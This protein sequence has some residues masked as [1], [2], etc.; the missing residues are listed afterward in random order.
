[1]DAKDYWGLGTFETKK[2]IKQ[3][4]DKTAGVLSIGSGGENMVKFANMHAGGARA[5]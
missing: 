5:F 1:L 3:E 4:V 2:R